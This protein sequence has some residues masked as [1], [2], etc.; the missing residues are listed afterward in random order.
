VIV[1]FAY[2]ACSKEAFDDNEVFDSTGLFTSIVMVQQPFS[3][4]A[5]RSTP[6]RDGTTL[7]QITSVHTGATD[8]LKTEDAS[9]FCGEYGT[10]TDGH[11]ETLKDGK[12]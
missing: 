2:R 8:Q 3:V 1:T 7:R 4:N 10:S 12:Q 6:V 5:E 9:V 11:V